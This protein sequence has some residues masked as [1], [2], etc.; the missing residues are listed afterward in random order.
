VTG[1]P[2]E[3]AIRDRQHRAIGLELAHRP[4]QRVLQRAHALLVALHHRAQ[5]GAGERLL[6]AE[7]LVAG[8]DGDDP[9]RARRQVLADLVVD[10]VL[11]PAVDELPDHAAGDRPDT[12]RREER[13]REQPD[14]ETDPAAPAR[15]LAAEMVARLLDGDVAVPV[16]RDQDG[17]LD[18]HLLVRHPGDERLEV[19]GR[20]ADV[21]VAR[22]EDVGP[23][24]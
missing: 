1:R 12:D 8:E 11:D 16:V 22:Y 9:R 15:A 21:L 18:L 23:L 19:P 5:Q 10:L 7:P 14:G 24:V 6:D 13:R 4:R 20:R 3:G 2:A 17:A